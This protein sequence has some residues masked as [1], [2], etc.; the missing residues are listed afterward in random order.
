[1]IMVYTPEGEWLEFRRAD[2]WETVFPGVP[3]GGLW[4]GKKGSDEAI[5]EFAPG[6]WSFVYEAEI[7][8]PKEGSK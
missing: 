2:D 8:D 3:E 6:A 1:M 5:A 7:E 4:I